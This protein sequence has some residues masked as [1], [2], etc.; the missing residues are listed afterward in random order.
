MILKSDSETGIML[1][2]NCVAVLLGIWGIAGSSVITF[3]QVYYW[4]SSE[5]FFVDEWE[6][7]Y[8]RCSEIFFDYFA[9]NLLLHVPVKSFK[10]IGQHLHVCMSLML[11][12]LKVFIDDFF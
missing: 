8:L 7:V 3:L 10:K 11:V 6:A 9:V 5:E 4:N 12:Q 1:T 2:L